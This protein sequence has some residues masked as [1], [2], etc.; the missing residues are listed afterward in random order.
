YEYIAKL[1]DVTLLDFTYY[2]C[3]AQSITKQ[4]VKQWTQKG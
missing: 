2:L 3:Y 4:E 1:K